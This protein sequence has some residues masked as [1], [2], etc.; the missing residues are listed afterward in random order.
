MY[1]D[2][3]FMFSSGLFV[4]DDYF[5]DVMLIERS[6]RH[7]T[8]SELRALQDPGP[9]TEIGDTHVYFGTDPID[10]SQYRS[11]QDPVL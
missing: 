6:H 10:P 5:D 4:F 2:R 11:S 8:C 9:F 7:E 3:F 1:L